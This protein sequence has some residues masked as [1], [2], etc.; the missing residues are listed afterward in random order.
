MS[1][2]M[3][4]QNARDVKWWSIVAFLNEEMVSLPAVKVWTIPTS[5]TSVGLSR[6]LIHHA[7]DNFQY[8]GIGTRIK[9]THVDSPIVK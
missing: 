2:D 5:R 6:P 1:D 3:V 7:L 8:L 9:G 4:C